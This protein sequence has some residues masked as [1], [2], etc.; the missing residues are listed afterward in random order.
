MAWIFLK[1]VLTR[2]KKK[3]E[4]LPLSSWRRVGISTT[5]NE[6]SVTYQAVVFLANAKVFAF[7]ER[8]QRCQFQSSQWTINEVHVIPYLH[9]RG[10]AIDTPLVSL[11][12]CT[13]PRLVNT[14]AQNKCRLHSCDECV[15]S[16]N[17]TLL[18]CCHISCA[19]LVVVTNL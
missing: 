5:G 8:P 1:Q 7:I 13:F 3:E 14:Q 12:S 17:V 4:S 19:A 2:Y 10:P 11:P 18:V 15:S 6:P 9:V 16:Q